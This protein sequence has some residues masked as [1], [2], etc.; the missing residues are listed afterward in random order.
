M[1]GNDQDRDDMA[2]SE[3]GSP[4]RQLPSPGQMLLKRREELGL[5][6]ARV[7]DALHLTAHYVRALE[8]D[9]YEKL[10]GKTF[11]KGYFKA[12]ARFLGADVDVVLA[13]YQ[14]C[15]DDMEQTQ[16]TEAS[17]IRARKAYDQNMR[18]LIC[19]A[20]II[21]GVVGISWWLSGRGDSATETAATRPPAPAGSNRV[22]AQAPVQERQTQIAME[23]DNIPEPE[24]TGQSPTS[25]LETPDA[26]LVET[27]TALPAETAIVTEDNDTAA[28]LLDVL[29]DETPGTPVARD[30]EAAE[31]ITPE[32]LPEYTITRFDDHRLVA[33]ESEGE[34]ILDVHFTGA[35]WIE[36]DNADNDRLYHDML[37]SGDDLS[38]RGK[39]PFNILIGDANM[40]DITFNARPVQISRIRDDN[41]VRIILEPETR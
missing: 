39:A 33:L 18:W 7:A 6:H 4:K 25:S 24:A 9:Q 26:D 36:I 1:N 14:A 3:T 37:R 38:I 41:S 21:V 32:G 30:D 27:V 12:Y 20:V 28:V 34:D 13:T 19:A 23:Q 16:D 5:S 17:V 22:Q 8:N 31:L 29:V 15:L 11:V 2:V 40:V 10:P 35:S